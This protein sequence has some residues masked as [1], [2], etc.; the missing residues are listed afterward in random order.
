MISVNVRGIA[1]V[2]NRRAIFDKY[3]NL[4]DILVLQETNSTPEIESIWESEWGGKIFFSHGVN[5][6]RGVA[7]LV[8]KSWTKCISNVYIDS[9]GRC[10]IVDIMENETKVT[11][12][13]IYA[14]NIDSPEY[15][16]NIAK[17]L[18]E[19][20]EHKIIIGDFNLVLDVELDRANTYNNNSKAKREVENIM[21]E[22]MMVDLW[23]LRNPEKKEYSWKKKGS[24]PSKASRIDMA[25]VSKGI[26]QK[27][28]MIDYFSSVFTD[29]RAV[30]MVVDLKPFERGKGYWKLNASLL[31]DKEYIDMINKE[32]EKSITSSIEKSAIE[33]WEICK[34]RIQKATKRY[35]KQKV[36]ET[37]III[38]QLSEK[39]DHYESRLPLN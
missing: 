21:E 1:S 35:S 24:Y 12:A 2:E 30:Y 34:E 27:V 7:I 4:I 15:F 29:H 28:E 32:L 37:S 36:S 25:L 11:L 14:P 3:R 20:Q 13:G 19:R 38:A 39:V 23:R 5:N 10:I 31:Q 8:K 18:K 6:A 22:Y 26:D 16:I 33:R 17:E 9:Q